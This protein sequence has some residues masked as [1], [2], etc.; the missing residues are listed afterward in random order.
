MRYGG[1]NPPHTKDVVY[2]KTPTESTDMDVN[3]GG[4]DRTAR[5]VLG[6]L[7]V[8]AGITGYAGIVRAA[9][10]PFPQ[11]LTSIILIVL[12]LILMGTG[13]T[14]KCPVNEAAGRNTAR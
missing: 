6:P 1:D 13:Y 12:G 2:K 11:A 3:V 5:L 8:L 10:D 14:R 9:F 7:L 4:N